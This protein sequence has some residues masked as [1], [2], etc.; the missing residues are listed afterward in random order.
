MYPVTRDDRYSFLKLCSR[1][2]YSQTTQHTII[3]SIT[4]QRTANLAQPVYLQSYRYLQSF[5]DE[6]QMNRNTSAQTISTWEQ[7][8]SKD[9]RTSRLLSDIGY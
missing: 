5:D 8:H 9:F 2:Q 1:S 4:L 7:R 3:H 6:F